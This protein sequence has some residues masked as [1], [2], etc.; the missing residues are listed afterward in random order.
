MFLLGW[1]DI[2]VKPSDS[3][4]L[5]KNPLVIDWKCVVKKYLDIKKQPVISVDE[6]A[7]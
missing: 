6:W 3:S 7:F 5:F 1:M 4:L 2:H